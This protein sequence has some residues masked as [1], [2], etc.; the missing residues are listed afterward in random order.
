MA[1]RPQT[2]PGDFAGQTYIDG[3]E[4]GTPQEV[5]RSRY[6][7]STT[8]LGWCRV[9]KKTRYDFNQDSD[10]YERSAAEPTLAVR[11]R[12]ETHHLVRFELP[13]VLGLTLDEVGHLLDHV[14]ERMAYYKGVKRELEEQLGSIARNGDK[15][16]EEFVTYR[17]TK[18][19]LKIRKRND[20]DRGGSEDE[21]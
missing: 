1:K 16:G 8:D 21:A 15:M 10:E 7:E 9:T 2:P 14:D 19:T 17:E 6:D 12:L 4:P 20:E 3:C 18:T 11:M 13:Q 5:H